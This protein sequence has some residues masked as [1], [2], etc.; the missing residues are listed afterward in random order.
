MP[1]AAVAPAMDPPVLAWLAPAELRSA[2]INDRLGRREQAA[3]HYAR[4]VELWAGA[5]AVHQP[6]VRRARDRL[7]L[8]SQDS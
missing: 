8:L 1:E 6:L 3:R 4:F 2:E 5:D 7:A